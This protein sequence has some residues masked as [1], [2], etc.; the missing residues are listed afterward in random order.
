MNSS[1][2]KD[3]QNVAQYVKSTY[4][5]EELRGPSGHCY[6]VSEI[7]FRNVYPNWLQSYEITLLAYPIVQLTKEYPSIEVIGHYHDG[8][9]LLLPMEIHEEVI[10][11]YQEEVTKLGYKLGLSYP[12]KLEIK[13]VYFPSE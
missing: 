5:D 11:R 4:M 8:N 12:Q 6:R 1:I 13:K 2:I 9:V 7:N 3:F 10:S